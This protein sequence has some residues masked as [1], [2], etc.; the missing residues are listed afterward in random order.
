M[1]EFSVNQFQLVN[2]LRIVYL[3]ASR[4]A[5]GIREKCDIRGARDDGA[6]AGGSR[7]RDLA[8]L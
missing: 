5:L 2:T 7:G 4:E 1:R 8:E 3:C 6:T